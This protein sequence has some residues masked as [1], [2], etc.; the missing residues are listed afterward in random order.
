MLQIETISFAR[1][2]QDAR[3]LM[4]KHA[5]LFAI[6]DL[7]AYMGDPAELEEFEQEGRLDITLASQDMDHVGYLAW[8]IGEH[9]G[10]PG[11]SV[12]RMGPWYVEP[13]ARNC[14]LALPMF[15]HSLESLRERQVDIALPTFP[16]RRTSPSG[17]LARLGARPF[18][19]T[20]FLPLQEQLHAD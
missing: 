19:M 5:K 8:M 12:A 1:L 18:E 16:L 6:S 11:K 13:S 9:Q 2:Q 10:L 7:D 4:E 17:W 20:W 3:D 14:R 15:R